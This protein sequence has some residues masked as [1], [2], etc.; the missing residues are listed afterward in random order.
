MGRGSSKPK[1]LCAQGHAVKA[2]MLVA[3]GEMVLFM[4]A[5]GATK[6]S[7]VEKLQSSLQSLAT[8]DTWLPCTLGTLRGQMS[9]AIC[10]THTSGSILPTCNEQSQKKCAPLPPCNSSMAQCSFACRVDSLPTG[11]DCM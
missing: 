6:V 10:I 1:K 2:G 8:G 9:R 11:P 4:D 3:R 7:D 5:D